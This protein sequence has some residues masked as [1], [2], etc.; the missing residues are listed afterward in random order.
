MSAGAAM[1]SAFAQAV[2][3]VS[4]P[5]GSQAAAPQAT[6]PYVDR[7]MDAATLALDVQELQAGTR[8]AFDTS[9]P[10]RFL[11]AQLTAA[12][13][14]SGRGVRL[15]AQ[16]YGALETVNF[17]TLTLRGT[18]PAQSRQSG[19]MPLGYSADQQTSGV[20]PAL[21]LQQTQMPLANG[22]SGN[23]EIGVIDRSWRPGQAAGTGQGQVEQAYSRLALPG[24]T[25]VGASGL[26]QSAPAAQD[27]HGAAGGQLTLAGTLARA[28]QLWGYPEPGVQLRSGQ[29]T[30]LG[31]QWSAS[32]MRSAHTAM[33]ATT[34]GLE[35]LGPTGPAGP[36][37]RMDW[38]AG[39][40]VVTARG[41]EDPACTTAPCG[42][43]A[44]DATSVLAVATVQQ[45]PWHA[46]AH[47]VHT[48]IQGLGAAST[49]AGTNAVWLDAQWSDD[50]ATHAMGAYRLDK[51]VRWAEMPLADNLQGLYYQG[52]WRRAGWSADAS[53]D[54]IDHVQRPQDSSTAA[55]F[56]ASATGRWRLDRRRTFSAGLTLRDFSSR[57]ASAFAD[58]RW[59]SGVGPSGLRL[60]G[61]TLDGGLATGASSVSGTSGPG[62]THQ[63]RAAWD[64]DWTMPIGMSLASSL[65]AG[66]ESTSGG[67]A[68]AALSLY[69]GSLTWS[70]PVTAWAAAAGRAQWRG[71]IN[72][73]SRVGEG[74]RASS[75]SGYLGLSWA[76]APHWSLQAH[77]H[78]GATWTTAQRPVLDPLAL[79][80]N[81]ALAATR[82]APSF[83]ISLRHEYQAGAHAQVYGGAAAGASG[84]AGRVSGVVYFDANGTHTKEAS[85]SGVEGAVV[86]LDG[87]WT[88]RT[89]AQGRFEFA[90]VGVGAHT[91]AVRNDS[92]ALP[93]RASDAAGVP[94]QVRLR[95]DEKVDLAVGMPN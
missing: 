46:S 12:S 78:H 17:G 49:T 90:L 30:S 32:T 75:V 74:T 8:E 51:G 57:A 58:L 77:V 62:S 63:V 94:L 60:E 4:T 33:T 80:T 34:D 82:T 16:V 40:Q 39:A 87:R 70:L 1:P 21:T 61:Y 93:W 47:M 2:A 48:D 23:H 28:A 44:L 13:P 10:A 37:L 79:P 84:G 36:A 71:N 24:F 45:G 52:A 56:Y 86:V 31:A 65:Y 69:G 53:L 42:R 7:V 29:R 3:S 54:L 27:D 73:D 85:E 38:T 11:H 5:Q 43:P 91:L 59:Q 81:Y 22:W 6:T 9:G 15:G 14:W 41:V 88:A 19:D 68:P 64:Q 20:G 66:R 67:A 72:V 95:Q 26:W 50:V 25:Q 89:D 55:G 18:M 83:Q 76:I 35:K 92:L